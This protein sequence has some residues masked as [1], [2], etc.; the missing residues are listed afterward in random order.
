MNAKIDHADVAMQNA[1]KL[2]QQV[3]NSASKKQNKANVRKIL[4]ALQQTMGVLGGAAE[5]DSRAKAAVTVFMSVL[6]LEVDR[7]DNE[8]EIVAVCYSMTSMVYVLR[9]LNS[10]IDRAGELLDQ[11]EEQ[12]TNMSITIKDFGAFTDVYYT[13]CK[14]RLVRFARAGEF[15]G[16][17]REFVNQ[18]Q[19]YQS[20]IEFVLVVRMA[21]NQASMAEDLREITKGI[22]TLIDHVGVPSTESQKKAWDYIKKH[23]IQVLETEE[24]QTNVAKILQESITSNTIQAL[25]SALDDLLDR[26]STL[27]EVK[28]RG[29]TMELTEAIDRST[30]KIINRMDSG[31]HDLIDD[32]DVKEIWKGNGWKFSVKCRTFIDAVSNHYTGKFAAPPDGQAPDDT[33]TLKILGK[34]INY[35]S[36]GEAMDEDASGFISV[37]EMNH[38]LKKN[39]EDST[40]TW[41][42]FWAVGP[43]YLNDIYTDEISAIMDDLEALCHKLKSGITDDGLDLAIDGYLDTIK[44]M[45]FITE[46][47]EYTEGVSGVEDMDLEREDL[48][49]VAERLSAK[50]RATIEEELERI[51]Y[52]LTAASMLPPVTQ[53][54]GFRIEQHIMLLLSVILR[55]HYQ[56]ISG[57]IQN[58]SKQAFASEWEAMDYTLTI[59]VLEFHDRFTALCRSWRSQKQDV[60]LQIGCYVGGLFSG[61][62]EEYT[63]PKNLIAK[64]LEDDDDEDDE[65]EDTDATT[66]ASV[67]EKVDQLT[68]RV[69]ALDTRLNTIE[70]MLKRIIDLSSSE[71]VSHGIQGRAQGD[72]RGVRGPVR[73]QSAEEDEPN[74]YTAPKGSEEQ[75]PREEYNHSGGTQEYDSENEGNEARTQWPD[76]D[77]ARFGERYNDV[78]EE[79][80]N[81]D[82][83]EDGQW[84]EPED[85]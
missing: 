84:Q 65:D 4:T 17:I 42:A 80:G 71:S 45:K 15:K 13:K 19:E 36:L 20:N 85:S 5:V 79:Q 8:D 7:R 24:G 55:K 46:W 54:T 11:L 48:V 40:P 12:I 10:N 75:Q 70:S 23:G 39:K 33:W 37:H 72:S 21:G 6:Q 64:W 22:S 41:F 44:I 9:H 66:P 62:Y 57:G 56:I 38:F 63:K 28:L 29:A 68:Q 49:R 60:A 50:Q 25:N 58:M 83:N 59:L 31:P 35:P 26:N 53:Q 67:E 76:P 77:A 16:K 51:D 14:S 47:G 74:Q 81:D 2:I 34:V 73:Q 30:N 43:L 3:A 1:G 32:P 18:F 52:R 82:E 61:W 78:S 69:S 27:F